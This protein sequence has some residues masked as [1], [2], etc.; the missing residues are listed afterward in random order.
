MEKNEIR[1]NAERYVEL[2]RSYSGYT[3]GVNKVVKKINETRKELIFLE[4]KLRE[5]GVKIKD[6]EE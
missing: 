1:E 3:G 4:K 6:L 2:L 5:V